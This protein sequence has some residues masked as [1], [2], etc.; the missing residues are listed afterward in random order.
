[1]HLY[2]LTAIDCVGGEGEVGCRLV[3]VLGEETVVNEYFVV[4]SS[5][6]VCVVA[7]NLL[8]QFFAVLTVGGVHAQIGHEVG[9]GGGVG[10]VHPHVVGYLA[11]CA[12]GVPD[13]HLVNLA[14]ESIVRIAYPQVA[15]GAE[16]RIDVGG[17]GA[18]L[19]GVDVEGHHVVVYGDGYVCPL[20]G[21]EGAVSCGDAVGIHVPS[22]VYIACVGGV[23][24]ECAP[25]LTYLLVV[26]GEVVGVYPELNGGL[27]RGLRHGIGY[28]HTAVAQLQHFVVGVVRMGCVHLHLVAL[29][30]LYALAL[31]LIHSYHTEAALCVVVEG[32][33]QLVGT[34]SAHLARTV[35]YIVAREG[36][37]RLL[38]RLPLQ[39][40][41]VNLK[42]DRLVCL[43]AGHGDAY[44]GR[45]AAVEDGHRV[46]LKRYL[47]AV[48]VKLVVDNGCLVDIAG[49]LGA[50]LGVGVEEVFQRLGAVERLCKVG[51]VVTQLHRLV[52]VA[53]GPAAQHR[54][55]VAARLG[56][57]CVVEVGEAR[58]L[59]RLGGGGVLRYA[60]AQ[61]YLG[62]VAEVHGHLDGAQRAVVLA[63]MIESGIPWVAA[64]AHAVG[65]FVGAVYH[66][67]AGPSLAP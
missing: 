28:K 14:V 29:R 5:A 18:C 48:A 35:I 43:L 60:C 8:Y 46:N 65:V 40:P 4:L 61:Q 52:V 9:D 21:L 53:V 23:E 67:L 31:H 36:E 56:G 22:G 11:L 45:L 30:R 24:E 39:L 55:L 41:C 37:I 47:Y 15:E 7:A 54:Y 33:G 26:G 59:L 44:H 10:Y 17:D 64:E 57:A 62:A 49:T 13:A 66:A 2:A 16:A 19:D 38:R 3:V 51:E 20:V 6:E 25:V 34:H 32:V 63:W 50:V 1:M 58:A 42:V 12:A 27:L